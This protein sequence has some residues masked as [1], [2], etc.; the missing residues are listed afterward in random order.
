MENNCAESAAAKSAPRPRRERLKRFLSALFLLAALVLLWR[1]C[2]VCIPQVDAF[3]RAAILRG[4]ESA[5]F[6]AF[7]ALR[8]ELGDGSGAV[9]AFSRSYRVLTGA[10]D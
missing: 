5:V 4:Q 9:A 8:E 7:S 6:R 10:A 2:R 3:A 1:T